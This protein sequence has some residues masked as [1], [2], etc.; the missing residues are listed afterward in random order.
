MITLGQE[1]PPCL[2]LRPALLSSCALATSLGSCA[3]YR[4]LL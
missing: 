1:K 2:S 3:F 4:G